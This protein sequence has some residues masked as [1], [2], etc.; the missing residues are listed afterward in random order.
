[1]AIYSFSPFGYEGALVTVEVDLRRGIPAI[2]IVGLADNAVKESRERMRSA[3]RNS[4]F[5]F[6]MERVLISLSPADLKKEGS[7]FDLPL[8]LAVLS[9]QND[10]NQSEKGSEGDEADEQILV[11]GELELSGSIR[12]VRAIHA[13]ASTAIQ[14]GITKCIVAQANA[15]EARE[16]AGM[17]V[18]GAS[19]LTEAFEALSK[20]E[21]FTGT[22]EN[23]DDF[24]VP[25]GSVNVKGVLFPAEDRCMEF[26]DIKNQKKLVR[27]LQV[28]AAGGHNILAYGPPG[29]GKTLALS[30][31]QALLP[32]L[33]VEE[34]QATTRIHSLAGLLRPDQPL[35]R[36]PPFRI[37]H[38]TSSVEG[39]C[40]GGIH[41]RPGEIS[42]AHN[43][44][45]FLD[46]AAEFRSSVL[47]MLRVP[48]E[49]G[50]ISLSRAGRTT[51]YPARFQLLVATNPCPCGNYGSSSKVCLCSMKSVEQYWRKFSGPLLDRIDIRI[52]VDNNT[53]NITVLD[54]NPPH[55]CENCCDQTNCEKCEKIQLVG[56]EEEEEPLSTAK[57]REQI[58]DAILI[59]R[60][61]Q[62]KRNARLSPQE[63]LDFCKLGREEQALLDSTI[64]NHDF[65]QRAVSSILKLSRT[66][67]DMEKSVKI[68]KEHLMEAI[69]LRLDSGPL[70]LFNGD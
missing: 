64:D 45:L 5:E 19:N 16:V 22:E 50:M 32:L 53:E 39:M 3:I 58:A 38:Q 15:A 55:P 57:L 47:Q 69:S 44:V 63:I 56:I 20:P 14:A 68:K 43:G 31:F 30:R 17:Q 26:A 28:A 61:R 41:C 27:A 23:K 60:E 66:I 9:A 21:L 34:S 46:E 33:T 40:G 37:P 2:D 10:K 7:G 36:I 70:D 35:L 29:C 67:A 65:S 1:M 42:L 49:N 48:I 52:H 13:A 25:E 51:V 6:P 8:A 18:F 59:Q 24:F 54:Q 62:G 12:P 4:G 11:V